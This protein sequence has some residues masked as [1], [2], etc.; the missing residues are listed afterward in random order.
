MS[1]FAIGH[2]LV[3]DPVCCHHI[4]RVSEAEC[5]QTPCIADLLRYRFSRVLAGVLNSGSGLF[6]GLFGVLDRNLGAL[7]GAEVGVY[8]ALLDT[9]AGV[10][11][12]LDGRAVGPLDRLLGAVSALHDECL[13]A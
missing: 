4:D 12:A 3:M 10:F 5:L 1:H 6:A 7:L 9:F 2:W 13:G 11:G 8:A